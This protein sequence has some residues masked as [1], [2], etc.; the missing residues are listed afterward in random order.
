MN[1]Q[2]I[3]SK[4]D[5]IIDNL[6]K[7]H[8]LKSKT[9]N[10]FISDFRNIDSTLHRLQTSIQALL[11]IGSYI[12]Y[13]GYPRYQV[14]V[15]GRPEAY[16]EEF[17]QQVYIPTQS[18]YAK[19]KDLEGK[20]GFKT[21]IFSITDQTPWGKAFLTSVV[22]DTDWKTVY[23]DDFMIVL[24]KSDS[25]LQSLDLSKLDPVVYSFN[26]YL[27]YLKLSL[28]LAQTGN[29]EAAQKFAGKGLSLNLKSPLGN[30]LFRKEMKNKFFW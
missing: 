21:I 24:V 13:R 27:S 17:F 9:Y 8:L 2:D 14:F 5:V 30:A 19:F 6:E 3:Q 4:V 28:F 12:I 22:K 23:I 20:L 26:G 29:T 10:D 16:P 11:D 1:R 15:D 25:A 18:D 7:L